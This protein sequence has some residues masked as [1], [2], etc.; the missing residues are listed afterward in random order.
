MCGLCGAVDLEGLEDATCVERMADALVHRGPDDRGAYVDAHASLGFLRLSIIDLSP[1]GHQP[2]T[3]ADGDVHLVFNGEIYNYRELR[4]DLIARGHVFRSESDSEVLLAS[5]L[6]WGLACVSQL[7]GMWAFAIWDRRARRLFCS[8]DRFGIKP[9]YYSC[10]GSRL[11]F[12]SEPKAF[13]AAGIPM[14]PNLEV[15]R[16]YLAFGA[17]DQTSRT[18]FERIER[19]PGAHSLVF[20]HHG[21]SV[22]RYWDVPPGGPPAGRAGRRGPPGV[23]GVDQS[24][25][26]Q[27]RS[28]RHLP[29]GRHR[30]LGSRV[31]R[32]P[33]VADLGGRNSSRNA[34]ANGHGVFFASRL[35]RA[36][37]RQSRRRGG[38]LRTAL[39]H[40]RRRNLRR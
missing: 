21:L 12:A 9:L 29:L 15:V 24:A 5:Y 20:D 39:G 1:L 36:T 4:R 26:A 28:S 38:R 7:R 18:F 8:V 31:H 13:A 16:D 32:R 17:V 30:L 25:P 2:M 40:L 23:P 22:V 3:A 14:A 10:A 27:R 6:E 19:L 11:V 33:S 37:V 35:R 34:S